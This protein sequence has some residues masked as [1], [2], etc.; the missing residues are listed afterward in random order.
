MK[1]AAAEAG[2]ESYLRFLL[3]VVTLALG[4]LVWDLVVR[5]GVQDAHPD[6]RVRDDGE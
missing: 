5:R 4:I 1:P 3:P 2:R 6:L